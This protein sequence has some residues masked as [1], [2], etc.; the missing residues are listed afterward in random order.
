MSDVKNVDAD[1]IEVEDGKFP[2]L[3]KGKDRVTCRPH[4]PVF[5]GSQRT[6]AKIVAVEMNPL[7]I[8]NGK[9][10]AK[11]ANENEVVYVVQRDDM[12][13]ELRGTFLKHELQLR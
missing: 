11:G 6:P 4:V 2:A 3:P 1:E 9:N 7:W 8:D 10:Q 5:I 12:G 13:P